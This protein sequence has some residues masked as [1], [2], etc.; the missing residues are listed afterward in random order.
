MTVVS[1]G[2]ETTEQHRELTALGCD[3]CQKLLLRSTHGGL[4]PQHDYST[5]TEARGVSQHSPQS[6]TYSNR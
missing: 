5:P 4:Q 2:V 1:D 6:L 3:S